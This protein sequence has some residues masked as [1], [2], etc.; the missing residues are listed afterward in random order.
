[1]IGVDTNVLLR[2]FVNDNEAQHRAAKAFFAQRSAGDPAFVSSIVLAELI[3]ALSKRYGY[4]RERITGLVDGI[5]SSTDFVVE[6]SEIVGRA[7]EHCRGT[8]SNLT[9]VLVSLLASVRGC[10]RTMT[11]DRDAAKLVPG[12]ELLK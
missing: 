11:F 8:N 10:E 1:M 3:W 4:P 12:M 5:A 7:V 6:Q 2:L 9:D